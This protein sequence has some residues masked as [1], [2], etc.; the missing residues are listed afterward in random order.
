V[1]LTTPYLGHI[2]TRIVE[3]EKLKFAKSK[4]LGSLWENHPR[5]LHMVYG[6]KCVTKSVGIFEN[7]FLKI[8]IHQK[9]LVPIILNYGT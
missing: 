8:F 3:D 6:V 7:L 1:T 2:P 5:I 9:K 4:Y